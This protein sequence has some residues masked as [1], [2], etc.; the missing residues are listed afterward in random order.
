VSRIVARLQEWWS[1]GSATLAITPYFLPKPLLFCRSDKL[2]PHNNKEIIDKYRTDH[3]FSA[4]DKL[5]PHNNKEI[6]DK[7]RTS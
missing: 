5:F 4:G 1:F 2:C 3:C 6:I 7:Y